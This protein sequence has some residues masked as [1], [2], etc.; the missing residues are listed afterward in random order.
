MI[1]LIHAF[2]GS[3]TVRT[4]KGF[5]AAFIVLLLPLFLIVDALTLANGDTLTQSVM[6]SPEYSNY[7]EKGAYENEHYFAEVPQ[8]HYY[9][10]FGNKLIDG[11]YMYGLSKGR[12]D[13]GTGMDNIAL[14]PLLL[15]WLNGLLQVGDIQ[16]NG[17][18]LAL[19]GDRIRSQFTPFS[20][21]QTLFA[22][23]RFDVFYKKTSLTFLTNRISYTGDYGP[24]VDLSTATSTADWLTGLHAMHKFGQVVDVT[25]NAQDLSNPL[26]IIHE[27]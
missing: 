19:I 3:F 25:I 13:L 11:F 9:D 1:P 16:D 27:K 8:W 23:A 7:A 10:M 6:I 4:I 14:H 20:F 5:S 2:S 21:K 26:F 12:N 24:V 17:G 18:V 15:R 22:G